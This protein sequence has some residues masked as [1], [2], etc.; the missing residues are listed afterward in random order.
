MGGWWSA[1]SLGQKR[2]KIPQIGRI[3]ERAAHSV[4]EPVMIAQVPTKPG[5]SY[6]R[7]SGS[8]V[9]EDY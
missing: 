5:L 7:T 9:G 2:K 6:G 1:G 3:G 8:V 4:L